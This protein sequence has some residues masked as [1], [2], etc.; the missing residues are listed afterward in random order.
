MLAELLAFEPHWMIQGLVL[1]LIGAVLKKLYH[2]GFR[3][4]RL[5]SRRLRLKYFNKVR[6]ISQRH[7]LVQEQIAKT[8]VYLA[9]FVLS[10]VVFMFAFLAGPVFLGSPASS[11]VLWM[12]LSIPI[13]V[14]ELGYLSQK[15]LLEGVLKRHSIIINNSSK[16]FSL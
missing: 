9:M 7:Y 15:T 16:S 1:I 2:R 4:F 6:H 3:L 14:L 11:R 12:F 5:F 8:Y 10:G 13:Y